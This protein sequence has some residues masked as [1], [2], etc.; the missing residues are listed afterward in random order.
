MRSLI[1][2]LILTFSAP[3]LAQDSAITIDTLADGSRA[4]SHELII[5]APAEQVWQAVGTVEG[6]GTW[7]VPLIRAVPGTDR[8]E[9][10]YDPTAAQG[11]PSGIE[12]QW[13]VREAPGKVVFRTTRTPAGFPHAAAYLGV[14]S[15]FTL[16]SQGPNATRIRLTGTGY[17]AGP[18]G[19]ALI[20]FFRSGNSIALR[21][22]HTRFATGPLDWKTYEMTK[23]GD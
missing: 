11:A 14:V 21:Q 18:D 5:P 6:W 4:M 13:L 23:K 3:S 19:D 15:T 9:T 1:A 12:Q 2:A 20:G 7:A 16:T 10:N 22:L 17:P 8:F